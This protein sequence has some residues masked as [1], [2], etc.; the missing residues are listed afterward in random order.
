MQQSSFAVF[1]ML[2]DIPTTF[3]IKCSKHDPRKYFNAS[4][5]SVAFHIETSYLIY[6]ANQ[7]TGFYMKRNSEMKWVNSTCWILINGSVKPFSM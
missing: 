7:M 5:P 3:V 1:K 6:T 2:Y 4:Q